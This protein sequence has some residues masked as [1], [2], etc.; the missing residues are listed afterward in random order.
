[1]RIAGEELPKDK[2]LRKLVLQKADGAVDIAMF[3]RML[4]DAPEFN[5]EAA[6]QVS[7]A[8]TTHAAQAED[9]WFSAVDDLKPAEDDA[10]AGH[11]GEHAFGSGV[12]YL[13]ACVNADLLAENLGGDREL[14]AKGAEAQ[15]RALATATPKGKQNSHAHHPRALFLRAET[16][17]QQPR[18]LTGAFVNALSAKGAGEESVAAL[19]KMS[20]DLARAYGKPHDDFKDMHVGHGGCLDEVAAFV[21]AAVLDG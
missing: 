18:D 5:R 21:R 17:P 8:I 2:E 9:D 19:K 6:V 4:A 14:A 16:G 11:I 13:Y 7:H 10:G 1:M 20:D 15:V 3:G 12:Y